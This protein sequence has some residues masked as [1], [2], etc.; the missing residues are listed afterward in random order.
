MEDQSEY[1]TDALEMIGKGYEPS[2]EIE[3]QRTVTE[4][5]GGRLVEVE[6]TAFVK[7]Y[8]SFKK[9]LKEIDGD[10][11]KIWLFLALSINRN[12][13][14]A[15]P[16]LRKI[17]SETDISINTVRTKIEYLESKGLLDVVRE[18]G[19]TNRYHPADYATVSKTDTPTVL[20]DEGTVLNSEPTVLT[21]RR[22]NAQLE[23]LESTRKD[24]VDLFLDYQYHPAQVRKAFADYFRLTPNWEAKYNKQFLEWAVE[25]KMQPEQVKR[26]AELWRSDKRF[27]W[28]PPSLKGIQEHWLELTEEPKAGKSE[29]TRLL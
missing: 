1:V 27:N 14:D 18:E 19:A 11:L 29:M 21:P 13:K 24:A 23:E 25:I 3:E 5:R 26:A 17:A 28:M 16:G 10:A 12:T 20:K 8:T 2:I 15:A 9:E 4:R 7:L 22:E 6:R